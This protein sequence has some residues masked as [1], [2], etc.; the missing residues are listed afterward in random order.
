[1]EWNHEPLD[2]D[3]LQ[4]PLDDDLRALAALDRDVDMAIDVEGFEQHAAALDASDDGDVFRPSA[5]LDRRM[6]DEFGGAFYS[7]CL[8]AS[9]LLEKDLLDGTGGFVDIEQMLLSESSEFLSTHFA[10]CDS[11]QLLQHFT[12]AAASTGGSRD[13]VLR[14]ELTAQHFIAARDGS[15]S[16]YDQQQRLVLLKHA[17]ASSSNSS[18]A[19]FTMPPKYFGGSE[20]SPQKRRVHRRTFGECAHTFAFGGS[21]A[22]RST[23]A[24]ASANATQTPRQVDTSAS[25]DPPLTSVAHGSV[26]T[27][28]PS[29]APVV[30]KTEPVAATVAAEAV[31]TESEPMDE[32]TGALEQKPLAPDDACTERAQTPVRSVGHFAGFRSISDD[33]DLADGEALRTPLRRTQ[34]SPAPTATKATPQQHVLVTRSMSPA[35]ALD[36]VAVVMQVPKDSPGRLGTFEWRI[37]SS[38]ATAA[39]QQQLP[40]SAQRKPRPTLA[41]QLGRADDSERYPPAASNDASSGATLPPRYFRGGTTSPQKRRAHSTTFG[42]F[43][44]SFSF[45]GAAPSDA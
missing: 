3:A 36:K 21:S 39:T 30:V 34:S 38:P 5:L 13:A 4:L 19:L 6:E 40:A 14:A 7:T 12:H 9:E 43:A 28:A 20:G 17:L 35:D 37:H 11:E 32:D 8:Q 25:A 23:G 18:S 31:K 15:S 22:S 26:A 44:R 41:A 2:D 45:T 1:M 24:A 29:A 27:F 33:Q 16:S 42:S 10:S